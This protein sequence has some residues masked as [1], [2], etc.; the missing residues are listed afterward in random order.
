MKTSHSLKLTAAAAI[1]TS[2]LLTGCNQASSS[3]AATTA[4]AVVAIPVEAALT[5]H[6][7][8]SSSYRTTATLEARAEAEV[9]SKTT[10]IV[11]KILV[12]EGNKVEAGQLLAV[13]DNERQQY[14]LNKEK[15]ELNRLSSELKRM[16]EMYQRKLVSA[17]VFEKLQWQFDALKS[18]VNLAELALKETE[19]RAPISGVVARRYA[20]LGQLV[21]QHVTQSLFYIVSNQQLEAVVHLPEQQLAQARIGQN[22][23]LQFAGMTSVN[24]ELVR[25]SPVV[26]AA[27]GTVRAV[28]KV[29]NDS[30]SLKPGMFAQVQLQFDVK[31]DALL[32]PKRA[33]MNTDNNQTVFV[34]DSENKVSRRP[35]HLGYQADNTVEVLSGLE[36]GEQVVIAGQSALKDAALV[37]V[38]TVREF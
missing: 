17:D 2:V 11:Q 6:G 24:S 23:L 27:S 20:K 36:L 22:A 7:E 38:V 9:I 35:V 33:L 31:A 26:D 21:N 12:E 25:I 16:E 37:N 34:I 28:L 10:G 5:R 19:I 1:L 30:Q 15:A 3:T 18:T 32:L 8:I 14:S 13:L 4:E 29:A